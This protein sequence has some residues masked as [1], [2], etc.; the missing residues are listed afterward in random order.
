MSMRRLTSASELYGLASVPFPSAE[1]AQSTYACVGTHAWAGV[2]PP[3][4][5]ASEMPAIKPVLT[6][7]FPPP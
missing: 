2:M 6:I 5:S 3:A 4:S 7:V 1:A